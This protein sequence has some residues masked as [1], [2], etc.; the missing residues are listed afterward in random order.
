VNIAFSGDSFCSLHSNEPYKA[1]T[2]L[3]RDHYNADVLCYG[4]AGY[5]LFHIYEK[6][7]QVVDKADYII[8][9]ITDPYRLSNRWIAPINYNTTLQYTNDIKSLGRY[10]GRTLEPYPAEW[11][12]KRED[13]GIAA[14]G[15]YNFLFY[16]E[17]HNF[18]QKCIVEKIDQLM[19]EKKKK[20][21]WFPCFENSMQG[22][23]PKSGPIVDKFLSK[24]SLYEYKVMGLSEAKMEKQAFDDNR[25]CH[26][27][28]VNNVNMAKLIIDIIEN[29]KFESREI[30]IEDYFNGN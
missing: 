26:M 21:I 29:N 8:F 4:M 23:I 11:E 13:I 27:N 9:C 28:E 15:Y 18:V 20:C 14:L 19:I 3:L 5:A 25:K 7:L 30:K 2:T 17:Y 12:E 6:L 16:E 10:P 1:W 24:I 22:F